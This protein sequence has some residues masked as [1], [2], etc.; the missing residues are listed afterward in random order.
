V[1]RVSRARAR[2]RARSR[3]RAR[4]RSLS[5]T[6]SRSRSRARSHTHSHTHTHTHTIPQEL[7]RSLHYVSPVLETIPYCMTHS[8]L[9]LCC[10]L[11]YL[12]VS[13]STVLSA[14]CPHDMSHTAGLQTT[15]ASSVCWRHSQP[16][17]TNQFRNTVE[18][19]R[20]DGQ[21][22]ALLSYAVLQTKTYRLWGARYSFK[23]AMMC[24]STSVQKPL[25]CS[26][27]LYST[28]LCGSPAT[29]H[30][31]ASSSRTGAQ[32]ADKLCFQRNLLTG[33]LYTL[34]WYL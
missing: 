13:T 5:R 19:V 21:V 2:A 34:R 25:R 32:S 23:C 31:F 33:V 27:H 20:G 6:L 14:F 17:S 9:S 12:C 26:C 8:N 7:P 1:L 3:S 24:Q 15:S 30:I 10:I 29:E 16:H 4:T 22:S 28:C 11:V 18:L